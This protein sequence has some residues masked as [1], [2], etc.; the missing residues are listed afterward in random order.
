MQNTVTVTGPD[1]TP[2]QIA[3]LPQFDLDLLKRAQLEWR[4][5]G[6]KP[7]LL[8]FRDAA[9]RTAGMFE[10]QGGTWSLL[11]PVDPDH[12]KAVLDFMAK[13]FEVETA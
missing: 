7:R 2:L 8:L 11:S 10:L 5:V 4:N 12:A 6:G 13:Q 3:G 1:G 9:T